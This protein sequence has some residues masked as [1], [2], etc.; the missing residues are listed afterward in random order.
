MSAYVDVFVMF[1][2]VILNDFNVAFICTRITLNVCGTQV[3]ISISLFTAGKVSIETP[4]TAV[5]T[6]VYSRCTRR[7]LASS[8]D[9]SLPRV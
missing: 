9:R 7:H 4:E 1:V 8:F 2:S 6:A 3:V 5:P